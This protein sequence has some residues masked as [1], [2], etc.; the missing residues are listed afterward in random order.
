MIRRLATAAGSVV[1]AGAGA[2]GW[3]L[4]E[5]R[6]FALRRVTA[7]VGLA[8][9]LRFLHLSDLHLVPDQRDKIE[10]VA[11]LARQE[12][13]AV[14]LTGDLIAAPDALGA[15]RDALAPLADRPGVFVFGS[16]DYYGPAFRNPL[17]YLAGPSAR[18]GGGDG[19]TN[20]LPTE[21][22][23]RLLTDLGWTDLNNRRAS[24]EIA[25]VPVAF[26]GTDDPHIGRDEFPAPDEAVTGEVRIGVTHAPYL[27]IVD[28]FAAD[29]ASLVFAGHTHGGQVAVPL[30][31]AL[32]TNCDLPT[33]MAKGLHLWQIDPPVWLHVSAG[34]GTSPMAPIR[35]ACR[36]EATLLTLA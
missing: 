8:K 13:D 16:N 27:R 2:L 19:R 17:K 33:D 12:F 21:E 28:A 30:Y 20:R 32:V 26:A 14:V 18:S 29:G 31:G 35:F 24:V 7:A 11:G 22:L 6:W 9:P 10:W 3:A 15:L 25:G 34:L 23:R 4:V 1:A 36:P 5:A